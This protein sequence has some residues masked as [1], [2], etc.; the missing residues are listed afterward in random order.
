MLIRMLMRMLIK[1]VLIVMLI[2]SCIPYSYRLPEVPKG[3][4]KS[5]FTEQDVKIQEALVEGW[6]I[7][8]VESR[9]DKIMCEALGR[10]YSFDLWPFQNES[11]FK[12]E[13]F[14]NLALMSVEGAILPQHPRPNVPA[15]YIQKARW[16]MEILP[17]RTC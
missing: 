3:P 6:R 17:R 7:K 13:A 14:H 5:Q 9:M 16:R 2:C 1:V 4:L 8:C 10:T 12:L 15:T 11:D